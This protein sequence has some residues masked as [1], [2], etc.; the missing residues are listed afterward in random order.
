MKKLNVLV[1]SAGGNI[2]QG[3]IKALNLSSLKTQIFATDIDILSVGLFRAHK[4]Y[5]VPLATD[6][7]FKDKIIQICKKDE[8]DAILIGGDAEQ[9][10]Y[11]TH[12]QEIESST[13]VKVIINPSEILKIANDK[14]LTYTFLRQNNF[15]APLSAL[16]DNPKEIDYLIEQKGFPLIIK[17]R[18][19][20]GSRN[21]FKVENRDELH[22]FQNKVKDAI[23]QEYVGN[24]DEEYSVSS[25][26][27]KNRNL[28]SLIIIKR[29]MMGG[30]TYKAEIV[31][32]EVIEKKV[33]EIMSKLK[34]LGPCNIQL[35]FI[36]K[37]I[38]PLEIN[39]RISGTSSIR[40]LFGFNDVEM[41]LRHFIL[42]EDIPLPL[43]KTGI[44]L[45]YWNELVC[46][47]KISLTEDD[48]VKTSHHQIVNLL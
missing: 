11:S 13:Q 3:I 15:D 39:A 27:D 31:E 23:I 2:G 26:S 5:V 18:T 32:N 34:P 17:P 19:G 10:S 29:L 25:F 24:D 6:K 8:I 45:R 21:I 1:T 40:A 38:Y 4:G 14:W 36:D 16:A 9:L 20:W 37:K 42:N 35:R 30:T 41:S 33:K 46:F 12:Q 47:D 28:V 48:V 22:V 43:I 7:K 44:A